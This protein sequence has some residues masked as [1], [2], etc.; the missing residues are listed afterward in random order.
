MSRHP[1]SKNA[2]IDFFTPHFNFTVETAQ[3][4]IAKAKNMV[5]N[6]PIC[7]WIKMQFEV[8]EKKRNDK[9]ATQMDGYLLLPKHTGH[10]LLT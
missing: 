1:Q 9:P 8:Q 5:R 4:L 10:N 6:S 2:S 3:A 7:S